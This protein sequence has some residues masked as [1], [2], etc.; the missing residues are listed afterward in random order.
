MKTKLRAKKVP[1]TKTARNKKGRGNVMK[2]FKKYILTGLVTAIGVLFPIAN[3]VAPVSGFAL[4]P[5]LVGASA[6][7]TSNEV[8]NFDKVN[9]D[10]TLDKYSFSTVDMYLTYD[11]MSVRYKDDEK[12]EWNASF[13]GK[14]AYYVYD[15][16]FYLDATKKSVGI[17]NYR[18]IYNKNNVIIFSDVMDI[19]DMDQ[20]Q[21]STIDRYVKELE[22][23]GIWQGWHAFTYDEN[24][25]NQN[26]SYALNQMNLPETSHKFSY[27]FVMDNSKAKETSPFEF[28]NESKTGEMYLSFNDLSK[29]NACSADIS[30]YY[31]E[32]AG[33]FSDYKQVALNCT[34]IAYDSSSL[35]KDIGSIQDGKITVETVKKYIEDNNLYE[36]C[37]ALI[38]AKHDVEYV[39]HWDSVLNYT[40]I[41]RVDLNFDYLVPVSG[42]PFATRASNMNRDRNGNRQYLTLSIDLPTMEVDGVW[43]AKYDENVIFDQFRAYVLGVNKDNN[44]ENNIPL[45]VLDSVMTTVEMIT[46]ET[47]LVDNERGF[48]DLYINEDP[49]NFEKYYMVRYFGAVATELVT[50]DGKNAHL[51]L[52]I[53]R[54]YAEYYLANN[55]EYIPRE[56]ITQ[57]YSVDFLLSGQNGS[58]LAGSLYT[59]IVDEYFYSPKEDNGVLLNPDEASRPD[60]IDPTELYGYWGLALVPETHSLNSFAKNCFDLEYGSMGTGLVGRM[61]KSKN[62]ASQAGDAKY[63][64]LLQSYGYGICDSHWQAMLSWFGGYT[65]NVI[66]FYATDTVDMNRIAF[67]GTAD[68]DD[69]NSLWINGLQGGLAQMTQSEGWRTFEATITIAW[70]AIVVIIVIWVCSKFINWAKSLLPDEALYG[71]GTQISYNWTDSHNDI[72]SPQDQHNTYDQHNTHEYYNDYDIRNDHTGETHVTSTGGRYDYSDRDYGITN[73]G[74]TNVTSTGAHTDQS[75][76]GTIVTNS[77]DTKVTSTG[78]HTDQSRRGTIVTNSGDTRVTSTG[79]HTN[80]SKYT[81][82]IF[83]NKNFGGAGTVNVHYD[84]GGNPYVLD[85][86]GVVH[87]LKN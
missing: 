71:R 23:D 56:G 12:K 69:N 70:C 39:D 80:Q 29:Y 37:K 18:L 75:R 68:G 32:D 77:G 84:D 59:M 52:N 25:K 26:V 1:A 33:L 85:Q 31:Y 66:M 7:T 63:A 2:K 57:H 46:Y 74:E 43:V 76:R 24:S 51:G 9:I 5:T 22:A 55:Y 3:D 21:I 87:W 44:A 41:K 17:I 58:S 82:H 62:I 14:D 40:A 27:Y 47:E 36:S 86:E 42:T 45:S 4:A 6:E 67:S 30:F 81:N 79:A 19:G 34:G 28:V 49:S 20:F 61:F 73:S 35:E 72:Y 16:S 8:F 60:P 15:I 65:A 50:M 83:N 53:N 64:D 48:H 13:S 11:P 78:A 10:T 54:S 38:E